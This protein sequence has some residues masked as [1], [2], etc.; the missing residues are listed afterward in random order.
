MTGR[1][2]CV[3]RPGAKMAVAWGHFAGIGSLS[4][5]FLKPFRAKL[6][7]ECRTGRTLDAM[8][9]P[10]NLPDPIQVNH[11]AWLPAWMVGSKA[12][13]ICGMPILGGQDERETFC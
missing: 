10:Q 12:P 2:W 1:K 9:R 4:E 13:V 5:N 7:R 8:D 6:A 11:L 3:S